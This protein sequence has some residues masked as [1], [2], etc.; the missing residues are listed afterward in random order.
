MLAGTGDMAVVCALLTIGLLQTTM[1][2]HL[3]SEQPSSALADRLAALAKDKTVI[4]TQ[5]S[6]GYLEFADNWITSVDA[7]DISNWLAVAQDQA[8]LDY[9]SARYPGHVLPVTDLMSTGA[10]GGLEAGIDLLEWGTTAFSEMAC[11][12]PLYLQA[13]LNLGYSV[14]YSDLD[15]AWLRD[16]QKLAPKR[17]DVVLV[18]DS[19]AEEERR[20]DNTGTGLMR[21]NP[22]E[23]AKALLRDWHQMCQDDESNAQPAWNKLFTPEKR[24][25]LAFHIMTKEIYPHSVLLAQYNPSKQRALSPAWVHANFQVGKE[26][27][28]EFLKQH[29]VWK[30][31]AGREYP[32]CA[33]APEAFSAL[34]YPWQPFERLAAEAV[35]EDMGVAGGHAGADASVALPGMSNRHRS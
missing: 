8:A 24:D 33:P 20:S 11:T 22:T 26:R 9:L 25:T 13:V 3:M 21:F 12:R 10:E 35:L 15:A 31:E 7:L 34:A 23:K 17:L 5:V 29:S 6:C 30:L 16:F 27:K 14:I 2:R 19:E 18:D 1:A 32:T 28:Q 4:V